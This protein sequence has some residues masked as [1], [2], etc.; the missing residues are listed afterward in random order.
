[1]NDEL[2]L[3]LRSVPEHDDVAFANAV[4]AALS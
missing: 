2:L 3:E 1:V 4:G